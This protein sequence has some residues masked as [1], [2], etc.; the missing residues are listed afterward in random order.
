MRALILTLV[1]INLLFFGWAQWIDQPV[2]GHAV[3]SS[4]AALQL[5]PPGSAPAAAG[6][7]A[8]MRCASLGPLTNREAV[9]AVGT[10]LRAR[11]FNP[12]ER[13]TQGQAP[14]GY[15]VYIDNLNDA[16]A[17]ARALKR[18]ARAGVRDAAAMA[19]SGQVSVGLFS[20]QSG[21]D[22][23]AAAVRS[24]GL[25]PVIKARLRQVDEYWFDVDSAS[26]VPLPAVAALM[27]GINVDTLPAWGACPI[28]G[29]PVAATH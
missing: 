12:H 4:V 5:A 18:L 23:R 14:D 11:S 17:R 26:D 25:E 10:A 21:A 27:A 7:S 15:W 20:E 3:S 16:D 24:A 13:V 19:T 2:V 9:V 29:G 8:A 6:A 22:L 1:F 28:A